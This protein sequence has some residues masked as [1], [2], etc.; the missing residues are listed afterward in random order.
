MEFSFHTVQSGKFQKSVTMEFS[1]HLSLS[2]LSFLCFLRNFLLH[3]IQQ[4]LV[5]IDYY[6]IFDAKFVCNQFYFFN[7]IIHIFV[8]V[9]FLCI[10]WLLCL[11]GNYL[12]LTMQLLAL[13]LKLIV[14][15]IRLLIH[16]Y[17]LCFDSYILMYE[18]DKSSQYGKHNNS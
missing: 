18:N 10:H 5:L 3:C 13:L 1:L 4:R 8:F 14:R 6:Y 9:G 16:S 15:N 2:H 11:I 7:L 17:T 12:F